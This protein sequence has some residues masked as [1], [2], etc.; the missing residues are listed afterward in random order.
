MPVEQISP[1]EAH[2]VVAVGGTIVADTT[3]ARILYET[4]LPPRY[5]IP[6]SDVRSELLTPT[7]TSTHC[8]YKG[9][10]RYWSVTVDGVEHPDIVW[11]YDEP[12]PA[13]A[14]ING[15]VSFYPEKVQLTVDGSPA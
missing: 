15:F 11:G 4:N 2:V 13:S 6:F 3:S 9:D 10:A 12:I 5:Y 14:D 7:N 1:T 8:P